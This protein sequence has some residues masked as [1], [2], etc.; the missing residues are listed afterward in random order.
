MEK[1][2][3]RGVTAEGAEVFWT[4]RAGAGFVSANRADAFDALNLQGAR[5][6]ATRLNDA[7][8]LHGVRFIAMEVNHG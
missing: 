8:G 4:G 3:I 2:I 7:T 1:A 5:R 6:T